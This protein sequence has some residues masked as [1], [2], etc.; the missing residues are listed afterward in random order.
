MQP[1]L[2]FLAK[3]PNWAN[4]VHRTRACRADGRYHCK[5]KIPSPPIGLDMLCEA[6]NVDAASAKTGNADHI[7]FANANLLR[8]PRNRKVGRLG[9]INSRNSSQ[10]MKPIRFDLRKGAGSGEEKTLQ[11]RERA[12]GE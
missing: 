10:R 2:F 5:R 8:S 3:F 4:R 9:S 7:P 12:A 11:S 1:D 6:V